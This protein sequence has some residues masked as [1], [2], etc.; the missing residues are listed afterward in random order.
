MTRRSVAPRIL[1][2]RGSMSSFAMTGDAIK[3]PN[4]PRNTKSMVVWAKPTGKVGL[5]KAAANAQ[6]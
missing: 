6:R 4:Q 3:R 5:V 2:M 1:G